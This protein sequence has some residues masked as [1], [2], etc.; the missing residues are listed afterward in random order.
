MY[1]NM[2]KRV[3]ANKEA[4]GSRRMNLDQLTGMVPKCWDPR[5]RGNPHSNDAN[6]ALAIVIF[7]DVNQQEK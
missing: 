4:R 1:I 7:Y 3:V 6:K 2:T 5:I